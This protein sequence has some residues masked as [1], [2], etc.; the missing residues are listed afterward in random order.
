MPMTEPMEDE[1][2]MLELPIALSGCGKEALSAINSA[3]LAAPV[4]NPLSYLK[5][6]DQ[7][8]ASI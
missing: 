4:P 5:I 2:I 1:R 6:S 7:F 3:E 8:A